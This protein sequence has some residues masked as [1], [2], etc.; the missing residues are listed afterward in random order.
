MARRLRLE[1]ITTALVAG[2]FAGGL[3]PGLWFVRTP[4]IEALRSSDFAGAGLVVGLVLTSACIAALVFLLGVL[5][6]GG[7]LW[8]GAHRFGRTDPVSAAVVGAFAVLLG[9]VLMTLLDVINV[10]AV[11]V[12]LLALDGAFVGVLIQR[13]AYQRIAELAPS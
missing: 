3:G 12:F 8:I 4:L 11:E 13:L 2:G 9:V 10:S 5:L 1:R 6:L 7:P